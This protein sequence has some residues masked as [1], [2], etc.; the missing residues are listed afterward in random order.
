MI[1][2]SWD[3]RFCWL[4]VNVINWKIFH[5][6]SFY[7]S[8]KIYIY[9][10]TNFIEKKFKYCIKHIKNN[11]Y[12]IAQQGRGHNNLDWGTKKEWFMKTFMWDEYK[13]KYDVNET[14]GK[15][16]LFISS[17]STCIY[18]NSMYFITLRN[19]ILS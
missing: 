14:K 11:N 19:S 12:S 15:I 13:K 7:V 17:F 9:F 4:F 8:Y 18:F 2:F 6:S 1:N 5:L 16:V 10:T 3:L